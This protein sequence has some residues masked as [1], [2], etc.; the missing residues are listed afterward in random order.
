MGVKLTA[1]EREWQLLSKKED[2]FMSARMKAKPPALNEKLD[3]H[4]PDKL[5]ETLNM[6]FNKAFEIIFEKGSSLIEKTYNKE[7]H[8]LDYKVNEYAARLKPDKKRI[9]K[10]GQKARKSKSVN[11]AISCASGIGLGLFGVGIPDIPIFTAAVF[12]SIYETALS[13]GYDYDSEAEKIFIL[14]LIET[15]MKHGVDFARSNTELNKLIDN[16]LLPSADISQQMKKTAQ[17]MTD[18]MIYMK[19]L[20]GIFVVGA[21]G[22]VWD[23]VYMNRI[24]DY[25]I[26]KYKRRFLADKMKNFN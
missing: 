3:P 7:K 2:K 5:R 8:E 20:Q 18:A 11:M 14:C 4:V 1:F 26:L 21:V 25:A 12:K 24:T 17:S 22:G 6:A 9:K 13:F 16:G 19:F 10:F 15:S 23:V